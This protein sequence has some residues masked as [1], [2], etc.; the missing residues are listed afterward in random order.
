M[1]DT[2]L[3]TGTLIYLALLDFLT[4]LT[5]ATEYKTHLYHYFCSC[6]TIK[7]LSLSESALASSIYVCAAQLL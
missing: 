6:T 3:N 4:I 2:I 1:E 5:N 7:R